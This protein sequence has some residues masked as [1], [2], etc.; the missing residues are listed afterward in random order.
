M[1]N[2]NI[3]KTNKHIYL[4]LFLLKT[5]SDWMIPVTIQIFENWVCI[6]YCNIPALFYVF[7]LYFFAVNKSSKT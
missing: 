1:P 6:N 3:E 7:F 2:M 4:Y 5:H